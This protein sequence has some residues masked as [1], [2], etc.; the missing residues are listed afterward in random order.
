[1]STKKKDRILGKVKL[2][3]NAHEKFLEEKMRLYKEKLE[4]QEKTQSTPKTP[5]TSSANTARLLGKSRIQ[6]PSTK[7]TPNL[8]NNDG[9]FLDQFLKM[10]GQEKGSAKKSSASNE[11]KALLQ[12]KVKN[13]SSQSSKTDGQ[14]YH[15][16][17]GPAIVLPSFKP[18]DATH[19]DGKDE[20]KQEIMEDESVSS[21]GFGSYGPSV[22]KTETSPTQQ[23]QIT[24]AVVTVNDNKP[25][26][27][28]ST[29]QP[30]TSVLSNAQTAS[31]VTESAEIQIGNPTL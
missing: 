8:F 1:M 15:K 24:A 7:S 13:E 11:S 21:A 5:S 23:K 17:V 22:A 10:T 31:M 14:K 2:D 29:Y 26:V 16:H 30:N 6:S 25:P 20:I 18:K 4:E 27:S 9:S 19:F 28:A 12:T 3:S